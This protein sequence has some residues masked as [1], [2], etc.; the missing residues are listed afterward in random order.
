MGFCTYISAS[1][2]SCTICDFCKVHG[3]KVRFFF[4]TIFFM[5]Y[6]S[7]GQLY[8]H[9]KDDRTCE[10]TISCLTTWVLFPMFGDSFIMV[11]E[12]YLTRHKKI[13]SI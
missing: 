8:I 6:F 2:D 7:T 13:L 9:K 10:S 5:H 11:I 4:A 12:V 3:A 1:Q